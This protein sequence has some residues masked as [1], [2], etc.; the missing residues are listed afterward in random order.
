MF[1]LF[2]VLWVKANIV[3]DRYDDKYR[4]MA[5]AD[6]YIAELEKIN[7]ALIASN[8]LVRKESYECLEKTPIIA[9]VN[10]M[11]WYDDYSRIIKYDYRK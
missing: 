7:D 5:K 3:V 9:V 11:S 4:E 1:V 10:R 6:A 2:I 8:R